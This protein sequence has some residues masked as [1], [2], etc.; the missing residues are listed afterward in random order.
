MA[1]KCILCGTE[2]NYCKYCPKDAKKEVWHTLYDTENCKNISKA[3]TD[4]NF[5]RINKEEAHALLKEC[6]LSL[7]LNDHYRGEINEIMA[8]PKRGSR[9][10]AQIVDEAIPEPEVVEVQEVIEQI[11]EEVK[12]EAEEDLC[13]VVTIE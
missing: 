4:Y 7:D 2:F 5:K 1:R 8:K 12:E 11:I 9:A 13:G 3:L 10:K 6:D